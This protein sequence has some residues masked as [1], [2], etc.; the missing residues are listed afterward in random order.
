[1]EGPGRSRRSGFPFGI[2]GL[3]FS[4]LPKLSAT[5]K[6]VIVGDPLVGSTLE[7]DTGEWQPAPVVLYLPVAA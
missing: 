3:G 2:G 5:P 7:V 4:V 1:M 6:P